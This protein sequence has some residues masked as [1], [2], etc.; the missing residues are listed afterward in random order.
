MRVLA[1]LVILVIAPLTDALA[2]EQARQPDS[3]WPRFSASI[4]AGYAS[5]PVWF[6]YDRPVSDSASSLTV[7]A[8]G[9]LAV[10]EVVKLGIEAGYLPGGTRDETRTPQSLVTT[11]RGKSL[12]W[13]T[14][15]GSV[16]LRIGPARPYL[17][18][19]L[20]TYFLRAVYTSQE[21]DLSG[22]PNLEEEHE[23]NVYFGASIGFGIEAR[24][25]LGPV[26]FGI[27]GV[28]H[29]FLES[30][31]ERLDQSCLPNFFTLVATVIVG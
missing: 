18:V 17:A 6:Y 29:A 22:A 11:H 5:D 27:Q 31:C 20:G 10:S 8:G 28:R 19:N 14:V 4:S 21:R 23:T 26:G 9:Y 24:Q 12:Y 1:F 7:G 3:K 2:Q 16:G 13:T 30:S 25:L 15:S